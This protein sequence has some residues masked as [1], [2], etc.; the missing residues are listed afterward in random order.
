LGLRSFEQNDFYHATKWL[1]ETKELLEQ[2][3]NQYV[4]DANENIDDFILLSTAY[5]FLSVFKEKIILLN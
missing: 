2:E 3:S 1:I 5:Y 4:N